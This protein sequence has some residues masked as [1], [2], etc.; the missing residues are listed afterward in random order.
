MLK[1]DANKLRYIL[2]ERGYCITKHSLALRGW[3]ERNHPDATI[4]WIDGAVYTAS[5]VHFW[6]D[7]PPLCGHQIFTKDGEITTYEEVEASARR[8]GVIK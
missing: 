8:I 5:V 6:D 3:G 1:R 2:N 4:G 7:I